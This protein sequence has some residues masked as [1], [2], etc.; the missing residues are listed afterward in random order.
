MTEFIPLLILI[1]SGCGLAVTSTV[2]WLVLKIQ[3]LEKENKLLELRVNDLQTGLN[4][5]KQT[6]ETQRESMVRMDE[7]LTLAMD[8]ASHLQEIKALLSR[9]EQDSK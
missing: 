2:G 5:A 7:R 4:L 6:I 3:V 8:T 1:L 9:Q